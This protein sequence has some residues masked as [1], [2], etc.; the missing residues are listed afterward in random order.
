MTFL[1]LW[2]LSLLVPTALWAV[3]EWTR[4]ERRLA[5]LLKALL[6]AAVVI[7]LAQPKLAVFEKKVALGLLV[8]TSASIPPD[9]LRKESELIGRVNAAR[10]PNSLHVIPFAAQTRSLRPDENP[11][12]LELHSDGRA[13]NLEA[14][15]RNAI[16]RLSEGRVPR[17]LLVSDGLE[18]TGSVERA[19]Y[20][21]RLLGIPVDTYA[22]AGSQPPSLELQSISMPAQAF[23]GEKFHI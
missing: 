12:H 22:L 14:A 1:H 16:A 10:G 8:D 9:D 7:A 19:I 11:S 13:T 15:I 3:W 23:T 6:L 2:V 4:T 5:L 18:N 17:I 21:A 20:Q